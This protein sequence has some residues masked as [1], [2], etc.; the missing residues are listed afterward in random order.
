MTKKKKRKL[1]VDENDQKKSKKLCEEEVKNIYL[2]NDSEEILEKSS[3]G[4]K[5]TKCNFVSHVVKHLYKFG[6]SPFFLL[7]KETFLV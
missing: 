2:K 5:I 6:L 7:Q 3:N 1:D 4:E